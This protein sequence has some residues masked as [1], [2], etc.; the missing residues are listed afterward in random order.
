M[1]GDR[2]W[3]GTKLRV[4]ARARPWVRHFRVATTLAPLLWAPTEFRPPGPQRG[5]CWSR[6]H[7]MRGVPTE[8]E[9]Y[10]RKS[11]GGGR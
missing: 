5:Q 6:G 11:V 9:A 1:P 4:W 8:G 2:G 3:S 10:E 7:L